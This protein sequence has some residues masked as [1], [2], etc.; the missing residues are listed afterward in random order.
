LL[1]SLL[2][3]C[4]A[5]NVLS[6]VTTESRALPEEGESSSNKTEMN[7]TP[8]AVYGTPD[9][10]ESQIKRLIGDFAS[11]QKNLWT[12]PA[13]LQFS[14]T[15]WLVPLSGFTAGLFVTD[16]GYSHSLARNTSKSTISRYNNLSNAGIAALVGG[17]AAMW[18]LSYKNHNEHWRETG[19]LAGEA[20]VSSLTMVEA[21]KYSFGR[22]RPNQG[23]GDGNF[24]SGGTS[25]P[26]EHAAAAWAA[27]G[28]VAHEYP[29][30]LTKIL[31]YGAASAVT[32]ARVHSLNH[33]RSDVLVGALIGNL[34]AAQVYQKRHDEELGGEGWETISDIAREVRHEPSTANMGSPYVQLDSWVYPSMERLAAMGY[35]KSE[36]LGM[37]PWTRLECARLVSEAEDTLESTGSN[38]EQALH[39]LA[40]LAR[41]FSRDI[42][43]GA[44]RDNRSAQ[45]ESLYARATGI[46]GDPIRD[47]YNNFHFGQTILNDYGRPYAQGVNAIAGFSGWATEGTLVAYVQGEYQQAG[48]SPA[49]PLTARN[50]IA[51]ADNVP[52]PPATATPSVSRFELMN[53][54]LGMNIGNWQLSF[55]K[56][57]LWLGPGEGGAMMFT[58]NAPPMTMFLI[59]RVAPLKLPW[60]FRYLGPMRMQ[61][62]LGQ[63]SD[64]R[65]TVL[66]K[67]N[68]EFVGQ[69]GQYLAQQPYVQGYK[70]SLKPLP[71]VEMGFT[72]TTVFLGGG[73]PLTLHSYFHSLFPNLGNAGAVGSNQSDGRSGFDFAAGVPK[74]KK[75][76]TF[77]FDS[78]AED[79]LSC[80]NRME[81]C[82]FQAGLYMPQIP[83]VPKLDLRIEGGTTSPVVFPTCNNGCFYTNNSYP[84]SYTSGGYLLGTWIGRASQGEQAVSTYW[85]TSRNKLQF[86]Y[87]HRKID[88]KFLAGGGTQNDFGA[89]AEVWLGLSVEMTASLQYE[90][91]NIPVLAAGPRSDVASTVGITFWPRNWTTSN[92]H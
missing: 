82:A 40:S 26:S 38:D 28:V 17:A 74:L 71:S 4:A 7:T 90:K 41:E 6:Q 44:G 75:W 18:V 81:K 32:Y 31:A 80:L 48:S 43:L 52:V 55:G 89:K 88:G 78:F 36:M 9:R 76:L 8:A 56:Q 35:V 91:W 33:Y 87:R 5:T 22:Q 3:F 19:F 66:P 84:E 50:A 39:L 73:T 61:M 86:A 20:A 34:A 10:K 13:H 57:S 47:I 65:F 21:M 59:N 79:E 14:D 27:A 85:L 64:Q 77:T 15:T 11:D 37:R 63:V 2:W 30:A 58:D 68:I 92:S 72:G 54:Y 16:A 62:F 83:G 51:L 1:L 46:S 25:F 45:I 24:F 70:I 29:G 42:E 69:W 49:L 67:P 60:I 12:S 53:A 23:N